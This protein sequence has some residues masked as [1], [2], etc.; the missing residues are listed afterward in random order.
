MAFTFDF[1]FSALDFRNAKCWCFSSSS[2]SRQLLLRPQLSFHF[3]IFVPFVWVVCLNQFL[4][5]PFF[6]QCT[7]N[8]CEGKGAFVF[9][10][11]SSWQK[12]NNINYDDDILLLI[13]SIVR[14]GDNTINQDEEW[15][16][17][18]CVCSWRTQWTSPKTAMQTANSFDEQES[19]LAFSLWIHLFLFY[20]TRDFS[21]NK[22]TDVCVGAAGGAFVRQRIRNQQNVV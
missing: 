6:R 4:F 20:W 1:F 18:V 11:A 14:C 2:Q 19:Y 8:I 16:S 22:L 13:M 7:T 9:V 21:A 12:E 3:L 10:I 15:K 17:N 5:L